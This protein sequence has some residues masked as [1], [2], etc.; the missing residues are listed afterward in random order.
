MHGF[1]VG[2]ALSLVSHLQ[3]APEPEPFK[4]E[5]SIVEPSAHP[6]TEQSPAP[7]VESA[8]P[9]PPETRVRKVETQP[10]T[11]TVTTVQT[12]QQIVHRQV[13]EVKP[14]RQEI[15]ESTRM[16]T[17]TLRPVEARQQATAATTETSKA[18]AVEQV[19][20]ESGLVRRTP[21]A[22]VTEIHE[23]LRRAVH[24]QTVQT[25]AAQEA[26]VVTKE[27][28]ADAKTEPSVI[29]R[30]PVETVQSLPQDHVVQESRAPVAAPTA[31]E[32]VPVKGVV[33]R[34]TSTTKADYGWLAQAL[35]S[36]VEKLKRYPYMA[37]INRW[38]GKVVLRAMIREDGHLV[39]VEVA[40]S[41][42]YPEL[43]QDALDV[44]KRASP[45]R[46]PHPLGRSQVTVRVPISYR[47]Q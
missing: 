16:V 24:A 11:Q 46:L 2:A 5:V 33:A 19:I 45:L 37:R 1:A 6:Q 12:T 25:V 15:V 29:A 9:T 35:W 28:V 47:L 21:A 38:E 8:S 39:E 31:I 34:S 10:T 44:V 42:G 26:A 3:L 32:Q 23:S 30:V 18:P 40:E 4:W 27:T 22:L 41:S 7:R 20:K 13:Q 14:V 17:H 36:R 43:D